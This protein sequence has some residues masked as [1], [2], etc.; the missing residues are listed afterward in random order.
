MESEVTE[1]EI[2]ESVGI[3]DKANIRNKTDDWR[4]A[5]KSLGRPWIR[6]T[7]AGILLAVAYTQYLVGN[8]DAVWNIAFYIV[9]A[10]CLIFESTKKIALLAIIVAM[11]FI[12]LSLAIHLLSE[13][14]ILVTISLGLVCIFYAVKR[15]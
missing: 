4:I 2:M 14:T 6:H 11:V 1:S 12:L 3:E 9:T 15:T 10:I 5:L 8:H 7:L 13:Q